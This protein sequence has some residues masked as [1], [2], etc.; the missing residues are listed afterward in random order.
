MPNV[1]TAT[2]ATKHTG[3]KKVNSLAAGR[4]KDSVA[5]LLLVAAFVV[6]GIIFGLMWMTSGDEFS[7]VNER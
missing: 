4:L 2:S 3:K 7:K 6:S 5:P 1:T